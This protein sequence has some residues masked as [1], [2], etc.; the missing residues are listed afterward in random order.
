[1]GFFR[2]SLGRYAYIEV[3]D[4]LTPFGV[5][6]VFLREPLHGVLQVSQRNLLTEP[7]HGALQV[8]VAVGKF[9]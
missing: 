4:L 2:H 6:R 9:L 3:E 7:H 8:S 1:M 5:G